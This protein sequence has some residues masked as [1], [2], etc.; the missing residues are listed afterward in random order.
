MS[1]WHLASR[2]PA[3]ASPGVNRDWSAGPREVTRAVAW[4]NANC[5]LLKAKSYVAG[6]A[7]IAN[8]DSSLQ[9]E[10]HAEE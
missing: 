10:L 4:L 6:T 8:F 5:Q 1:T 7:E 3:W 2:H 9:K